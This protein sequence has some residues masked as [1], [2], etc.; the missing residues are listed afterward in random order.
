MRA[1]WFVALV[2][3]GCSGEVVGS[4]GGGRPG[5]GAPDAGLPADAVSGGGAVDAGGLDAAG[6]GTADAAGGLVDAPVV[7]PDGDTSAL[8]ADEQ[9]LLDALNR[10]RVANGLPPVAIDS[11]LECAARRHALDV[12]GNGTCGHVGSDGSW[13]WDR[14][15]ACGF[16][17]TRWTVNE[18]AA[19]PGF[20]SGEDAVSGWR[21]SPGHWAAIVHP[22][23]R[24]VGVAVYQSCYIADF[25]CCVEG[26]APVR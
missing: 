12:G 2:A 19:G 8:T 4:S 15:M 5:G 11:R 26:S 3:L 10:A 13:P 21:Q 20:T 1:L 24:T 7:P 9:D 6:G 22:M 23:A 16:D 17:Q 14:A 25:D 18:I